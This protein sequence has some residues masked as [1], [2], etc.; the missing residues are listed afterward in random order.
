MADAPAADKLHEDPVTGEMVSKTELKKRQKARE[1]ERKKAEKAAAA[2][3]VPSR[4]KAK[5]AVEQEADLNPNVRVY[6]TYCFALR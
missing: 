2:S 5:S 6:P 3:S 1:T 4:P